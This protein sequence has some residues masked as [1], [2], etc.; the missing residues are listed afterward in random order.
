MQA[1]DLKMWLLFEDLHEVVGYGKFWMLNGFYIMYADYE[2]C[3]WAWIRAN[4]KTLC[5]TR[6]RKSVL[7]YIFLWFQIILSNNNFQR[8]YVDEIFFIAMLKQLC[9]LLTIPYSTV[10]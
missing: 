2:K 4:D 3:C 10:C 9:V 6:E 8:K 7:C 1:M 5:A